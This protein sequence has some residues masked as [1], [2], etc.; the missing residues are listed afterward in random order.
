M[1]RKWLFFIV[2]IVA[3]LLLSVYSMKRLPER[4]KLE[5]QYQNAAVYEGDTENISTERN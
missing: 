1:N 5:S 4:T 2:V 3:G